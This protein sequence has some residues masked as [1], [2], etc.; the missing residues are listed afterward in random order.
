[1]TSVRWNN[2][3]SMMVALLQVHRLS[4]KCLCWVSWFLVSTV[5]EVTEVD[6]V[7]CAEP[8]ILCRVRFLCK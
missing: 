6:H 5:M 3:Q 2:P 1:M 7:F 4:S 8:E